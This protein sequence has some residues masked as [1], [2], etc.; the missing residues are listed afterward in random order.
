M[1][2]D[3]RGRIE[4]LNDRLYSRTRY[5]D[6]LDTRSPVKEVDP[7][8]GATEV[9][10]GWKTPE[11]DELL[12][13]E[14]TP[15]REIRPLM[16]KI[17]IVALVF[18]IAAL[19]VAG[20]V[21]VGGA[22][23]I[24]S[25]NVDIN[26]IGPT[27]IRAG[28]VLELGV[29][30]SNTNNADLESANLSIQ[31]PQGTE[32]PDNNGEPLTYAKN[33]L[34]VIETG[35]ETVQ[36]VRAVL[37][38][39]T[40]EVKN[41]KFSLEYKVKGS[42]ATFYKDKMFE[43]AIG[44]APIT[45]KIESPLKVISGEDFTI[46]ASITMN[47]TDILK[48][49]VLKTEYPHGF[50]I[51]DA[52]PKAATSDNNIWAL[53]DLSPADKKTVSI[54]GKLTG[55]DNEERTFRFYI[56][57]S[58]GAASSPNLKVNIVSQSN[59]IAVDRPPVSLTTLF[60]GEKL[61]T[62]IAPSGRP[63]ATTI[64]FQ[65][66]LPGKLF[67]PRLEVRLSGRSLDK[68]SITAG[69]GSSYDSLGSKISWDVVNAQGNKELAP[70]ENG[71]VT[72]RFASLPVLYLPGGKQD[73]VLDL[74]ISGVEIGRDGQKPVVVNETRSVRISSQINLSSKA[75]RSLGPFSNYGP[76]PPKVKEES[77]YTI[78]FS[79]RNTQ[80]DLADAKVSTRLG[81]SVKWLG[82]SSFSN[83]DISYD[84]LSN[85]VTWNLGNLPTDTDSSSFSR[86][87]SFQVALTPI[88][89]QIGTA[90]ILVDSIFF[91]GRDTVSGQMIT[92]NNSPLTT[93]LVTDPAFVQGD[94]IVT[95]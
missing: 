35:A 63:I 58:D 16:K 50:S 53:G 12:K 87:M 21:F 77:S 55:E 84:S 66:N 30:I 76:I 36:N 52:T 49:V 8:S 45:L 5:R 54:K 73:I 15:P 1:E 56:G 68:T 9:E 18:F 47:S 14:R 67:N 74:T 25:K 4:R 46:L 81:P 62:Y 92:T 65:N 59:T 13:H 94:E 33:D 19:G 37:I 95:K 23:F 29:T 28:E 42:N 93:R 71:Q 75:L 79:I 57:V 43:I 90:P 26:V 51:S 27:T 24:S 10:E 48:N 78:T 31:Y 11:L 7:S 89:G 38:G 86:E 44:E 91:S 83:E 88:L 6:P 3:E 72:M 80:G 22:T 70:G 40:G 60:N 85:M 2:D 82:A 61:D 39:Q 69:K 34:G 17:F 32:N 41:I 20:F 64:R